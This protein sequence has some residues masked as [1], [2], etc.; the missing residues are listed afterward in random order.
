MMKDILKRYHLHLPT[1]YLTL[2]M[3]WGMALFGLILFEILMQLIVI[4]KPD[5]EVFQ[6]AFLM[7]FVIYWGT[8]L[9]TG[10]LT[11]FTSFNTAIS[12]GCTRRSYIITRTIFLFSS[13]LLGILSVAAVYYL[14]KL[15][16][17]LHWTGLPLEDDISF[18]MNPLLLLMMWIV[19]TILPFFIN[20]LNL[21]F[22]KVV[23][24]I[25][26]VIWLVSCLSFAHIDDFIHSGST[27]ALVRIFLMLQ[28]YHW[29]II[30][31]AICA[32]LYIIAYRLYKK[33]AV[34]A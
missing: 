34:V 26:Y 22:G 8:A 27:L 19:G 29:C 5:P 18:L 4:N 11:N 9:L 33:Q 32:A 13:N 20:A 17:N 30:L 12:M 15:Y 16:L 24:I 31:L 14:E 21:R 25:I 1:L 23:T 2:G 3:I 10:G 7:A 6:M 28:P